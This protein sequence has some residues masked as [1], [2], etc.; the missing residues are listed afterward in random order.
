MR[1]GM[2]FSKFV[3]FVL[4]FVFCIG[5]PITV[6]ADTPVP[7]GNDT[8]GNESIIVSNIVDTWSLPVRLEGMSATIRLAEATAPT[9]VTMAR[10]ISVLDMWEGRLVGNGFPIIQIHLPPNTSYQDYF[11]YIAVNSTRMSVETTMLQL[12]TGEMIPD[13]NSSDE[14]LSEYLYI[15]PA[16]STVVLGEGLYR[17]SMDGSFGTPFLYIVVHGSIETPEPVEEVYE[18]AEE[19]EVI[20]EPVT[21]T[22][23][24]PA[25]ES[26]T[27]PELVEQQPAPLI[28]PEPVTEPLPVIEVV[29]APVTPIIQAA[30]TA[31]VTNAHFLNLRRGAGV[32]YQAFAVLARGDTV[33]V[34]DRSGGWV[35]VETTKG[36]GW[37]FGR[38]LDI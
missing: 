3:G 13:P 28:L 2:Q 12:T 27:L 29:A 7:V 21:E 6:F 25:T 33:T 38:Y 32:N 22:E 37:V 23:E 30:N 26:V 14:F 20:E 11:N 15:V 10:D 19:P 9:T 18:P 8:A 17:V 24:E 34:L 16:G 36:T 4:V 1:K 35:N 31:T 5:L